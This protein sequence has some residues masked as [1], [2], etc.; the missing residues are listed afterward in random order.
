MAHDD[1][2]RRTHDDVPQWFARWLAVQTAT[3][4]VAEQVRS[5]FAAPSA[6]TT[7][8]LAGGIALL[9]SIVLLF[10]PQQPTAAI[11]SNETLGLLGPQPAAIPAE[12][13]LHV[14]RLGIE[15]AG[16]DE[17]TPDEWESTAIRPAA[18]SFA[19]AH[20]GWHVATVRQASFV[21]APEPYYLRAELLAFEDFAS[22]TATQE[23]P[24]QVA[25]PEV[26][27]SVGV[28][29][30]RSPATP[31]EHG[32]IAYHLNVSNLNPHPIEHVR[33]VETVPMPDYVL[34]TNPPAC[35]TPEGALVWQFANL[36]P[37]ESRSM[38]V[39]LD[40]TQITAPLETVAALDVE[41][42][43][44]VKTLVQPSALGELPEET[45][46]DP[47]LAQFDSDP[48]P[49][50]A[51]EAIDP[52]LADD[53]APPPSNHGWN[54]FG[55]SAP[56]EDLEPITPEL[57]GEAP[58]ALPEQFVPIVPEEQPVV[59]FTPEI[60]EEPVPASPEPRPL[61]L[62]SAHPPRPL[63]SVQARARNAVR[64]GDVLTTN[65][66]IRNDGDAPAEGIVLR[67]YVPPEL[68]HK[69]GEEVVHR[70]PRLLPGQAHKA[71]LLTKAAAA[72]TA[73]LDAVLT[74][75]GHPEDEHRLKVQVVG[76][77]ASRRATPRPPR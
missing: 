36:Q 43:V 31:S 70:V 24:T 5:S 44:S 2:L 14:E 51:G 57:T 1:E 61:P 8:L 53:P 33:I 40:G 17:L 42:Q 46:I 10:V 45:P 72:G 20:D 63:L 27:R 66:E 47:E 75:D 69:H 68:R 16:W 65:Y 13:E 56:P 6:W 4:R 77:T 41:A 21:Q 54:P 34:D 7:A 64:T 23:T 76:A 59:P 32:S 50:P 22:G 60:A 35:M 3:L 25:G 73:E 28:V 11:G 30:K 38:I 37:H 26:D 55:G 62:D 39:T 18:P 19:A 74:Y 58:V 29:L 12:V 67:V 71:R 9:L 15:V 48:L 49:Q 52:L